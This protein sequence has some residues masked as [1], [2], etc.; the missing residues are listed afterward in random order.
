MPRLSSQ[1]TALAV[2]KARPRDKPY[3]LQDG[4]GLALSVAVSGQKSWRVRYRLLDGRQRTVVIGQFPAMS[5]AEAREP[6][7][8]N[9]SGGTDRC[10]HC[11]TA[12]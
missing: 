3:L 4:D 9:P 11:G 5:L 1:L 10:S 8:R 12:G 2:E 7:A 6:Y